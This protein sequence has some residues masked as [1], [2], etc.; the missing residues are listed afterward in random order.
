[1]GADASP[2]ATPRR[3]T[4]SS[5]VALGGKVGSGAGVSRDHV[6]A[7]SAW[8]STTSR[9]SRRAC[10]S[11]VSR[12]PTTPSSREPR[13]WCLTSEPS[14]TRAPAGG[15]FLHWPVKD[16]PIPPTETLRGLVQLIDARLREGAVVFVHC[17]A[18]RNR[19]PLV[20]ARVL[21]EQGMTADEAIALGRVDVID[22]QRETPLCQGTACRG[23]L[24]CGMFLGE[25]AA[26]STW[27]DEDYGS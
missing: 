14:V 21:M 17:L 12:L 7:R 16:G 20:A 4:R 8:S 26:R 22:T 3:D 10:T 27:T 24:A 6:H 15:L 5:G 13:S 11:A 2:P 23:A 19:S 18:G 1:M 25:R 9:R